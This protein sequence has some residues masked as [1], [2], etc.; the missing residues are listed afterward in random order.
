MKEMLPAL[1]TSP[2]AGLQIGLHQS[3]LD[4]A[5]AEQDQVY[6]QWQITVNQPRPKVISVQQ[7]QDRPKKRNNFLKMLVSFF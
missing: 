5:L 7:K 2:I 3:A 4:A 6:A 1:N